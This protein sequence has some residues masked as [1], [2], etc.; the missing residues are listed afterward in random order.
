M[1]HLVA[2]LEDDSVLGYLLDEDFA[3]DVDGITT[4]KET[5]LFLAAWQGMTRNVALLLSR[6]KILLC[7]RIQLMTWLKSPLFTLLLD[8]AILAYFR[9]Y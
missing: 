6:M 2:Y 4:S 9:V 5:G 7:M 8:L 3:R 1:L